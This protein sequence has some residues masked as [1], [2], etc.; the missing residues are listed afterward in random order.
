M[1][2]THYKVSK[3]GKVRGIY[4]Y[5]L[6]RAREIQEEKGWYYNIYKRVDSKW[7]LV[8]LSDR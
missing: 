7:K 6:I 8:K 3:S 4:T 1:S 5:G 2:G